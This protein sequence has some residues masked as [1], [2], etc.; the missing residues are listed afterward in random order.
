MKVLFFASLKEQ[1]GCDHIQL[2]DAPELQTAKDVLDRLI[3]MGEPWSQVLTSGKVLIAVNQEMARLNT[4]VSESDEIA[5][6]PPV[7]GG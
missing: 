5:F 2:D 3:K 7:T 6:F 1:L 4:P